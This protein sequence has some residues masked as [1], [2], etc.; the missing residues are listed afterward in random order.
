[1]GG[2][3]YMIVRFYLFGSAAAAAAAREQT[4]WQS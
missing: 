1:M 2:Q 3:V 4:R